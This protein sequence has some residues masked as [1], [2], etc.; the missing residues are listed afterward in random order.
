MTCY[1]HW[2]I[3][4]Q[5]VTGNSCSDYTLL[6]ER[7]LCPKEQGKG[8]PQGISRPASW[9]ESEGISYSCDFH[10]TVF[11]RRSGAEV[12]G[13]C[14]ARTM[15]TSLRGDEVGMIAG[16]ETCPGQNRSPVH[17]RARV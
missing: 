17:V 5:L 16:E 7:P 15:S 10:A 6:K 12:R 1:W 13:L 9:G 4:D 2:L 8:S 14:W 3:Q 11:G